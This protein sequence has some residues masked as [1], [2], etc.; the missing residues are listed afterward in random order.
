MASTICDDTGSQK[1]S[2]S[3]GRMSQSSI[4]TT[5]RPEKKSHKRQKTL[6]DDGDTTNAKRHQ[7]HNM[8]PPNDDAINAWKHLFQE[9]LHAFHGGLN[10]MDQQVIDKVMAT[11]AI[12]SN[13][14][15]YWR[16]TD[17]SS[18]SS[19]SSH[20]LQGIAVNGVMYALSTDLSIRLS[21]TT[22]AA[23]FHDSQSTRWSKDL[24]TKLQELQSSLQEGSQKSG[25]WTV[26]PESG[27]EDT[28][29]GPYGIAALA[30]AVHFA[31][32]LTPPAEIHV[33]AWRSMFHAL[34][35]HESILSKLD[36]KLVS[37]DPDPDAD[38]GDLIK[39]R[40]RHVQKQVSHVRTYVAYDERA[41]NAKHMAHIIS[42][43]MRPLWERW[44]STFKGGEKFGRL[45]EQIRQLEDEL[46]SLKVEIARISSSSSGAE[47]VSPSDLDMLP[48]LIQRQQDKE[49]ILQKC[50]TDSMVLEGCHICLGALKLKEAFF[51]LKSV[52]EQYSA[53][54]RE[55]MEKSGESA[56]SG[57]S[58]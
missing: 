38:S 18:I 23:F 52:S 57:G 58:D 8:N 19:P 22:G 31:V 7:H 40:N 32:G 54:A 53:A 36:Q 21:K 27:A 33:P 47:P 56:S 46:G 4:V 10:L 30:K 25:D 42:S 20:R 5:P 35:S 39:C 55:V 44:L 11:L 9:H 26:R 14:F 13:Q 41:N 45:S 34:F 24:R 43:Q 28:L 50:Q 16:C 51:I 3:G 29:D 6:D 37:F 15:F 2:V 1:P 49:K 48:G 12:A 17:S